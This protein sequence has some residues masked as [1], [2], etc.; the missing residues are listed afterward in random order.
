M[1]S[2]GSHDVGPHICHIAYFEVYEGI[3]GY[4]GVYT[5]IRGYT[6]YMKVYW[7]IWGYSPL[8]PSS[9]LSLPQSPSSLFPSSVL[10]L[11]GTLLEYMRGSGVSAP[12]SA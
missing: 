3:L 2:F 4:M 1:A 11:G 10:K 9:A 5:G 6:E 12:R 8:L 7:G